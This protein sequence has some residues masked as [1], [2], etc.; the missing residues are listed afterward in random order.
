MEASQPV[1]PP[2]AQAP[3]KRA[4]P[5]GILGDDNNAAELLAEVD[6]ELLEQAAEETANMFVDVKELREFARSVD[7]SVMVTVIMCVLSVERLANNRGTRLILI[8]GF[9]QPHFKAYAK[10]LAAMDP[11]RKDSRVLKITVW[12]PRARSVTRP[13]FQ[14]GSIYELKKVHA[15]KFY[16]DVLQG[17]LQAVGPADPAVIREYGDFETVKRARNEAE[18][19]PGNHGEED[20]EDT[21]S[22]M[23]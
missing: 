3:T 6:A 19:R 14:L 5:R 4:M 9:M 8:D 21:E 18:G 15:L 7:A 22:L 20:G 10:K 16:H 11:F 23:E 1:L 13:R 17:S 2:E 12:D